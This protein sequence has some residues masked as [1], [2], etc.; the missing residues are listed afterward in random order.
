MVSKV[1]KLGL[2]VATLAALWLSTPEAQAQWFGIR[3]G[4]RSSPGV[5]VGPGG[6]SVD[7]GRD[8][9]Y[10]DGYYWDGNYRGAYYRDGYP[11]RDGWYGDNRYG[12][13]GYWFG[14]RWFGRNRG[15]WSDSYPRYVETYGVSAPT[16]TYE[17]TYQES[18]P[19]NAH[20]RVRVPAG[21]AEVFF[22]GT[23]TEQG[24]MVRLFES[25]PLDTGK[26]YSPE[27]KARWR[28]RNGAMM[29]G[30]RT[31]SLRQGQES[32][33]DFMRQPVTQ[34]RQG[35]AQEQIRALP[36]NRKQQDNN[37]NNG[38]NNN[39]N[40]NRPDEQNPPPQK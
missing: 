40:K 37:N 34:E 14:G 3:G 24:G 21:D 13:T 6:V 30:K 18:A 12:R 4:G 2:C 28:G 11:Y 38:N 36:T 20:I 23:A 39:N 10:G 31:V 29:E 5:Y 26:K 32:F 19:N 17:T 8:G 9:Y 22:D 25:P 7:Y 35:A 16:Q 27:I 15:Y 33:V 1:L